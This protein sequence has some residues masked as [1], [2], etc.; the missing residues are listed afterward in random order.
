MQKQNHE[1][2]KKQNHEKTKKRNHE[3]TKSRKNKKTK[4]QKNKKTLYD[5]IILGVA[6]KEFLNMNLNPLRK[7]I[8]VVYDVKGIL[9]DGVDAK[10]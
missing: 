5:A 4:L 6:H 2:T 1:K 9:G 7:D 10:L 8:S 3:T